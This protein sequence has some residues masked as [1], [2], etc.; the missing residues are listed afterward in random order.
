MSAV[1][2]IGLISEEDYLQGE[3]ASEVKHQLV[4]GHVYAMAG[5][6]ENHDRISGNI[7]RKFGN[8]LEKSPCEPFTSDMKLK[9]STGNFRYPDCMVVCDKDDENQFYKTKPVILV[10]VLSRSTRKADEKDKLIEYINIPT[11]Q[12]YVLIEQ[13]YVDITVYRKSD[14]WHSVHYFLGETLYFESIDLTLSVEEIYHRV[15]NDDMAEFLS[16]NVAGV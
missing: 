13:D 6:S 4:D 10:E 12:E 2:N 15:Q 16:S 14:N 3:M 11:L 1:K 5:A 9:T 7:Y 8:H